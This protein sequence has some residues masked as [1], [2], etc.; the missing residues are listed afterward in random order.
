MG[1]RNRREAEERYD[2][3]VA[4]RTLSELFNEVLSAHQLPRGAD[5]ESAAPRPQGDAGRRNRPL[6]DVR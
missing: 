1:S 6:E 4:V 5:L 2:V 3:P